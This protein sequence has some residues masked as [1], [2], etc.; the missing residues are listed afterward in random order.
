[1]A[2]VVER[3]VG[4]GIAGAE[5]LEFGQIHEGIAGC[6]GMAQEQKLAA[7]GAVVEHQLVIEHEFGHLQMAVGDIR[8]ARR[9]LAGVGEILGPVDAQ[10]AGAVGLGDDAGADLGE[11]RVA[12]GMVAVVV[13][14][15]DIANR[16]VRGLLD[17]RDHVARLLGKVGVEDDDII[18]EDH[19]DIIAAAE[20]D[21]LV[22]RAD[23]RIAKEDAR[24]DLANLVE[25]HRRQ[26]IRARDGSTMIK[27]ASSS[28][29]RRMGILHV[30]E[31]RWGSHD[32]VRRSGAVSNGILWRA[33]SVSDRW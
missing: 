21:A 30:G 22:G 18:L 4:A 25:L 27:K 7:L 10:N 9:T 23:R 1:M 14:I 11:D 13:R 29:P 17:G 32:N 31:K 26:F 5:N 2:H 3:A 19:P 24:R 12:I 6:V 28:K 16:L 33:G 20:D 15:D 8:A